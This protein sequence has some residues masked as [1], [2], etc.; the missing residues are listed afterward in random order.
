MRYTFADLVAAAQAL[1]A[2]ERMK[3]ELAEFAARHSI[4]DDG[5]VEYLEISS[6]DAFDV[7]PTEALGYFRS[8]GLL[9]SFSYADTI[10]RVNDQAF[11]VAKMLDVDLLAQVRDSLDSALSNGTTF[12]EWRREL[13]PVLKAAGWWGKAS[14]PD[15]ITGQIVEAQ[16]GSAWRLETIFR[17]NLQTA[18]AAGQW[19]EIQAQAD[20]APFLMYDAVDDF[21][22]RE[23]HRAWDGKVL[24]VTSPWWRTHYPPNGWNC[25]CGVIQLDADQLASMGITPSIEPSDGTYTWTNP[26]TGEKQQ[27]P[28]GI[29]PGFGRNAGETGTQDLRGLLMEKAALLPQDMKDALAVSV[30][31]AVPGA[32]LDQAL[33]A[34]V[35]RLNIAQEAYRRVFKVP[36][37]DPL[38]VDPLAVAVVL[39]QA[40]VDG[41]Q[42]P[43]DFDWSE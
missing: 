25:R 6:G 11:T 40:I 35:A 9:P 34:G 19:R 22:T 3:A 37:P 10:G 14:M 21:R 13:E 2:V 29:D 30:A 36:A 23:Q 33:S 17:T 5:V 16:L 39:E 20:L 12:K 7:P 15:P 27:V 24:P 4:G 28:V 31:R 18:Y 43:P 8:K 41:E 1:D 32:K 42:V 38:G 26:R